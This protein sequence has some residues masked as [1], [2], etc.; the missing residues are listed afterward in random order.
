MFVSRVFKTF[1]WKWN[2]FRSPELF[3]TFGVTHGILFVLKNNFHS[4]REIFPQNIFCWNIFHVWKYF[5][6]ILLQKYFSQEHFL[7]S[8]RF[9]QKRLASSWKKKKLRFILFIYLFCTLK[10][11]VTASL[12]NF[13]FIRKNFSFPCEKMKILPEL[14]PPSVSPDI[15]FSFCFTH[16]NTFTS[17][18][19][20]LHSLSQIKKKNSPKKKKF[21]LS[22]SL[23][24]FPLW[25]LFSWK[26][27]PL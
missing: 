26:L 17:M 22:F 20:F 21:S 25:H 16:E 11:K 2:N 8:Y 5:F 1:S 4:V 19:T 15:Y 10:R 18:K 7:F 12:M 9:T 3:S 27:L 6:Q 14:S 24:I 23:E 13:L